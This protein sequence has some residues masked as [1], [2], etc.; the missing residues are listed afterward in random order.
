MAQL[1]VNNAAFIS[2]I[3]TLQGMEN[4]VTGALENEF[5]RSAMRSGT[6]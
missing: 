2:D 3:K 6:K 5:K 1:G 4:R